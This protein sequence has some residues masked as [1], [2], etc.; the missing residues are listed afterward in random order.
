MQ[1]AW[2]KVQGARI[3]LAAGLA[4]VAV[5]TG[6][7]QDMHDQPKMFPQRSTP[8][9]ADGRSARPQVENTVGRGQLHEDSYFYTGLVDG[10]EGDGMPFEATAAVLKRGQER[11]NIY[12]TPCHSR[13]GNGAGEIVERGYKLAGNFHTERLRSAPLGHFFSVMTNGYGAMP[14]YSAQLTPADRWAVAAYV[15]ALQLSQNAKPADVPTGVEVKP[16]SKLAEEQG[17]PPGY[18]ADWSVPN[19]AA[20]VAP[21][22]PKAAEPATPAASGTSSVAP[23]TGE[24]QKAPAPAVT[25]DAAPATAKTAALTKPKGPSPED[26]AAGK[27]VYMANCVPCHQATR[28]GLPPNIPSLVGIVSRVGPDRIR[29]VVTQG[30]ATGKIQMPSFASKLNST[31]IDHL[32]AYLGTD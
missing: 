9:F 4:S 19:T 24:N 6:C 11:Y 28:T 25:K 18:A 20:P 3:I 16:L 7:R 17:M 12:C 13:V 14:D 27:G 21:E 2:I 1:G 10:K 31:D 30:I 23:A 26:I 15:R 22:V 8:M 5:L 32:I 29:Q